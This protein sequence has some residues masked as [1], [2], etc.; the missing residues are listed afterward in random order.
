MHFPVDLTPFCKPRKTTN[1][2]HTRETQVC[3]LNAPVKSQI[4]ITL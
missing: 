4:L 1:V 3:Q 2:Q